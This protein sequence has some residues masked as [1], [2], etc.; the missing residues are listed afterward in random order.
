MGVNVCFYFSLCQSVT[1]EHYSSMTALKFMNVDFVHGKESSKT[2][3]H[4]FTVAKNS[5]YSET[6]LFYI[7]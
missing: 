5:T 2:K 6:I 1:A 3:K 7:Q 4:N